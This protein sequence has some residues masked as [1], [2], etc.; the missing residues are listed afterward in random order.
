[1]ERRREGYTQKQVAD[2]LGVHVR[3]VQRWE[4]NWK[5]LGDDGLAAAP[6]A[7]R[8]R[9]LAVEQEAVVLGWLDD[10]P[11]EHG[12]ASELWTAE[13]IAALIERRFGVRFHPRYLN[14]WLARRGVS[15]QKP[16]RRAYERDEAAIAAWA[17]ER[18]PE[19]LKKGP[20]RTRTSS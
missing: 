16:Q 18:W 20:K 12:F 17:R 1:M 14:E 8:P 4:T 10:A 15:P 19:I 9:K 5:T 13:R 6:A 3:S 11:T 2:F 7:G